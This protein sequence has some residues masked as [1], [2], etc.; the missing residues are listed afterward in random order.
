MRELLFVSWVPGVSIGSLDSDFCANNWI[1]IG[2]CCPFV[3]SS[4]RYELVLREFHRAGWDGVGVVGSLEVRH[5]DSKMQCAL[6]SLIQ[7]KD[8]MDLCCTAESWQCSR[9]F[10]IC[11]R[12]WVIAHCKN[13]LSSCCQH[14]QCSA[15]SKIWITSLA[16]AGHSDQV[17]TLPRK[18]QGSSG[19]L[20][21]LGWVWISSIWNIH[22]TSDLWFLITRLRFV[23]C[24]W[25]CWH[26]EYLSV[27]K[28]P[29][30]ID[31]PEQQSHPA[32]TQRPGLRRPA[33]LEDFA[34]HTS[35]MHKWMVGSKKLNSCRRSLFD[36]VWILEDDAWF[37]FNMKMYQKS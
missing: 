23:E 10:K 19:W 37:D 27:Q 29:R 4:H 2:S 11:C 14:I 18:L 13:S 7:M 8:I 35:V 20:L 31:W 17:A 22:T 15:E 9:G 3:S 33:P 28:D 25:H 12:N 30:R 16:F 1:S 32:R 21:L 5:A 26:L 6:P 24:C 36:L 34:L